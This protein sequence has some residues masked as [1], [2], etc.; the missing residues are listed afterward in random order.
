M[1]QNFKAVVA[2]LGWGFIALWFAYQAALDWDSSSYLT[3]VVWTVFMLAA[4]GQV[5]ETWKKW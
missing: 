1:K 5:Q 2:I 3:F 4:I